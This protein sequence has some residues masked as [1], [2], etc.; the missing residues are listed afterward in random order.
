MNARLADRCNWDPKGLALQSKD[1]LYFS[2]FYVCHIMSQ[3]H[4]LEPHKQ[5]V[6]DGEKLSHKATCF[7]PA[8]YA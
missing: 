5:L 7:L 4:L 8:R 2:S 6:I 3:I 1:Y